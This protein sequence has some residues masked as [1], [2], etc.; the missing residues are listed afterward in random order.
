[1]ILNSFKLDG[2]VAIVTGCDIGLGQGMALGLAN[3]DCDIVAVNIT[4]PVETKQ[5]I[6]KLGRRFLDIRANLMRQKEIAGIIEQTVAAFGQI[7]ILVNNTGIT[8][9]K[10]II[11][12]AND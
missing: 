10:S 4:E 11:I 5:K 12:I 3:A 1:M 6:E 2:K 7:E 8:V 9:N